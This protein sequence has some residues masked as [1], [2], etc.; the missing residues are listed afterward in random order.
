MNAFQTHTSVTA[1]RLT[2]HMAIQILTSELRAA[3]AI[4]QT[5]NRFMPK[6]QPGAGERPGDVLRT[7]E[8]AAVI[9]MS[10]NFPAPSPSLL[11]SQD[12]VHRL[13]TLA[14]QHRIKPRALDLEAADHIEK[15][16]AWIALHLTQ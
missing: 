3:E 2:A 15:L 5:L 16:E 10:D 7:R 9:T 12:L 1:S 4:I 11:A 14:S 13:R 6:N 8:R